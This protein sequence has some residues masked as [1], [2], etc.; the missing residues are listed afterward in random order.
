MKYFDLCFAHRGV[1]LARCSN[2]FVFGNE[3]F[4]NGGACRGTALC[5]FN[6]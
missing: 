6:N 5:I 2:Y 3:F 1:V 4:Y